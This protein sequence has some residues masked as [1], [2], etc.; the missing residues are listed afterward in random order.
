MGPEMAE[1]KAKIR[2]VV[3]ILR[4]EYPGLD[5]RLALVGYRDWVS[6]KDGTGKVIRISRG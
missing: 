4:G 2:D 1:C 3:G 5:L 6:V